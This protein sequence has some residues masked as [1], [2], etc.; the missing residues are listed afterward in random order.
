M[1]PTSTNEVMKSRRLRKYVISAY[2]N[3]CVRRQLSALQADLEGVSQQA[4]Q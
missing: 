2:E 4:K 3:R 1:T